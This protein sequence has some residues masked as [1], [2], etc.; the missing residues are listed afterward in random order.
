MRRWSQEVGQAVITGAPSM[1]MLTGPSV[2]PVIHVRG[3]AA[4]MRVVPN[5]H[6]MCSRANSLS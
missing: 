5:A 2:G 4:A 6:S 3:V 1:R